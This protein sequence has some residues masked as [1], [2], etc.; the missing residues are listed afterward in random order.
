[1]EFYTGKTGE[2]RTLQTIDF[3]TLSTSLYDDGDILTSGA[4]SVDSARFL[5]FSGV[6]ERIILKETSS[7]TLQKPDIRMWI[8]GSAITPA[9]Q[10]A[11]QAFTTAQFDVLIGYYDLGTNWINGGTGVCILQTSPEI[12]YVCQS[13]SRTLYLVP[14][15]RPT[16]ADKTFASGA[17]IKGQ[18][19]LR[20]D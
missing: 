19:V 10:N 14:E 17:T 4:I 7:G 18:I 12:K 3:G 1:M 2:D 15:L 8:F 13:T 20:R 5:G 16:S 6:I 11:P 9:A